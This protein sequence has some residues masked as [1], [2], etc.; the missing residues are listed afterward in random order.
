MSGQTPEPDDLIVSLPP[1]AAPRRRSHTDDC[2][3]GQICSGQGYCS[4]DR[5]ILYGTGDGYL[6][7]LDARTGK[8]VPGFGNKGAS[9]ARRSG[10]Q[11]ASMCSRPRRC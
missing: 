8:Q 1:D 3:S 4:N 6:V 5:R 9:I 10:G 7:A 11:R 2:V